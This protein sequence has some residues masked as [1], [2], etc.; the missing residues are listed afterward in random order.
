MKTPVALLRITSTTYAQTTKRTSR[1]TLGEH[2]IILDK[3]EKILPWYK[4][5]TPGAA[6]THV[7][8][9]ASEFI[10]SDTP[11][12]PKTGLPVYLVTCCFA[13]P[14]LST[15]EKFK[16]GQTG[17][18]WMHNPSMM[19]AGMVYSL[20]MRY[21]VFSGDE[22]Y[23]SIVKGYLNAALQCADALAKNVRDMG[24]DLD[25][26]T[27]SDARKSPW[28][29]ARTG[30]VIDAYCSNVIE[31]IRLFDELLRIQSRVSIE[32]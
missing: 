22:S 27:P 23:I 21:R 31:P 1:D 7:S 26:F 6:Y 19:Y 24:G 17:E 30:L 4:P 15:E 12:E 9:L 10:K 13:E 29:F 25:Y 3:G 5:Q 11:T 18:R 28:P 16:A 14:H 32:I 20:V 2:K 8:K